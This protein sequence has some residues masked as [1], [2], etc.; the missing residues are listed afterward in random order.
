MSFGVNKKKSKQPLTIQELNDGEAFNRPFDKTVWVR[1][2]V[3]QYTAFCPSTLEFMSRKKE[4]VER[5][6]YWCEMNA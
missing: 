6:G 2:N 3:G 1:V 5:I 4:R